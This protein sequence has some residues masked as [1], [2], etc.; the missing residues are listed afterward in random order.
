MAEYGLFLDEAPV[1]VIDFRVSQRFRV[2]FPSS[3]CAAGEMSWFDAVRALQLA[4]AAREGIPEP[5]WCYP[6][7]IGPGVEPR[8]DHLQRTG[9]RLPTE[10][11]WEFAC[12]AG[13]ASS[14]FYGG[15]AARLPSY[16]WSPSRRGARWRGRRHA[17]RRPE[18]ADDLG[19]FDVLGNAFEWCDDAISH[20]A[21]PRPGARPGRL[22]RPPG[23]RSSFGPPGAGR[24]TTTPRSSGRPRTSRWSRVS[25]SPWSASARPGRSDGR[26]GAARPE[27]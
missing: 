20:A 14:R 2:L 3:D 16:A 12:R 21:A 23:R 15:S 6:A 5:E 26:A 18:D 19:L 13:A 7:D 25:G 10:A 17:S 27:D 24:S 22:P 9:Y 4:R 11:E 8:P 1:G